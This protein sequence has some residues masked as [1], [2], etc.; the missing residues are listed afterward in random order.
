MQSAARNEM[1]PPEID[2]P[3]SSVPTA[4][5]GDSMIF[6]PSHSRPQAD[7]GFKGRLTGNPKFNG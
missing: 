7:E 4:S 3:D 5:P 1:D 2:R 6:C